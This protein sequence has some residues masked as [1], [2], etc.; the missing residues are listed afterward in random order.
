MTS[1]ATT[2]A[3]GLMTAVSMQHRCTSREG[4]MLCR[5]S[6]TAIV[7]AGAACSSDPEPISSAT[8]LDC[9]MPGLLPFRLQSS[10]FQSSA[11]KG[12]AAANPRIKDEA[13]DAIGNPGGKAANV[14]LADGASPVASP[15]DYHGA[16]ARTTPTGGL[17]SNAL[18][19]ENVSLWHYDASTSMW[20]SLGRGK[21][22]DDGYYDLPD[23]GFVASNGDPIFALLEADKT[24][25]AHLDYML[26]P[27]SKFIVTDIDGTLTTNDSELIMEVSDESHVPAMMGAAD[28]LMQTWSMKKY[29]I[30]YLTARPHVFR[31]E[32]RGWLDML[33]FP[34]G[35]VITSNGTTTAADAYKTIWLQ[36]MINDFGW[37]PVAAYGNAQTDINAYANAGI[38]GNQT[39]IVGG[40]G[41]GSS[42]TVAIPNMDFSDHITTYV[43]AQPDNN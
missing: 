20:S 40:L 1:D 16:K 26:P 23:T 2:S 28:R 38:P 42:G 13:S 39:F 43:D 5:L 10:G 14:Y 35:P 12:V 22:G 17:F 29:P 11:T 7:L 33:S 25:A 36:R 18:A 3:A 32:T 31:T 9:P 15:V 8:T 6:L 34:A 21:T 30:V 27:G 19:G 4:L 41:G 24:C 37:V